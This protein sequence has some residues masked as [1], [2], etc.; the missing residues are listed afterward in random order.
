[1]RNHRSTGLPDHAVFSR[2]ILVMVAF[3]FA[4]PV[5][6]AQVADPIVGEVDASVQADGQRLAPAPVART[7]KPPAASTWGPQKPAAMLRRGVEQQ[8]GSVEMHTVEIETSVQ[9][10]ILALPPSAPGQ[11]HT[12]PV[13]ST[14]G[15]PASGKDI[16]ALKLRDSQAATSQLGSKLVQ[17]EANKFGMVGL[18]SQISTYPIGAPNPAL[19]ANRT[20]EHDSARRV[21][22]SSSFLTAGAAAQAATGT[23]RRPVYG[24]FDTPSA[25]LLD[26][27]FLGFESPFPDF[28]MLGLEPGTGAGLNSSTS[29]RR[30]AC[31]AHLGG[32]KQTTSKAVVRKACPADSK[33]PNIYSKKL[34]NSASP[35]KRGRPNGLQKKNPSTTSL[36]ISKPQ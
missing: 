8:E 17:K 34:Q 12:Q 20:D 4:C 21:Q 29:A 6:A 18:G 36:G 32:L 15:A 7:V 13:A 33:K 27:A 22:F 25:A 1:M 26:S 23:R 3:L 14:W 10:D 9:S 30:V 35:E 24:I 2:L 5:V 28:G 16:E 31:R 11:L 19:L